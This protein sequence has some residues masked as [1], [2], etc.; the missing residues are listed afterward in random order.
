MKLR[1]LIS[2]LKRRHIIKSTIAYLAISWVIIQIASTILP[3]FDA[4]DYALKILIYILAAGLVFWIGFSWYYDLTF[5][6]IQKTDDVDMSPESSKAADRRLNKVIAGALSLG[7][8]LLLL[9][10]FWAGSSWSDEP[11]TPKIKKVAVIPFT[12]S[13][14]DEEEAY[15]MLGHGSPNAPPDTFPKALAAAERAIEL[16]PT[17][18]LGWASLSHYHTY[19][20]KDWIY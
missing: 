7:V 18:A 3:T 5:D 17:V 15:I 8:V 11:Y 4:P 9:I 10:S 13:T 16:D 14:L 19:L 12:S 20:G 2:E 6:G 1:K